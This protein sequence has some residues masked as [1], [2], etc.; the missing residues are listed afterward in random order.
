MRIHPV[1]AELF[2]AGG[3]AD[4]RTGMMKLTVIFRNFTNAPK[5]VPVIIAA[6]DTM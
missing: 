4:E 5:M 3:R 2:H 1:E 6:N